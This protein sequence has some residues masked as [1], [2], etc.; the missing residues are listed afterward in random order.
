MVIAQLAESLQDTR[1]NIATKDSTRNFI[2]RRNK[3]TEY[4]E[5]NSTIAYTRT[6][7]HSFIL[8]HSV[9]GKLGNGYLGVDGQQIILG[10]T[11][12]GTLTL[13]RVVNPNNTFREHFRNTRFKDNSAC[14]A[15]WDTTNFRLAMHTSNNHSTVYNTVATF[16]EIFY[17]QQTVSSAVVYATETR[18]APTDV[19]AYWLSADGG[20]NWQEFSVGV[21]SIFTYSGQDLRAKIIFFGQGGS[22]TWIEDLK[23]TYTI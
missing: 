21:E 2:I 8:G 6:I 23:I 9:N 4:L 19:I 17:N 7:G 13:S 10:G 11:S 5:E 22:S 18:Y 20:L 3:E 16:S 15:N 14:T 12:L 1:D